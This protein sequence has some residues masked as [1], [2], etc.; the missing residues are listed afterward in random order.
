MSLFSF[1][2]QTIPES[3]KDKDWHAEHAK[4]FVDY[5]TSNTYYRGQRQQMLKYYR[6]YLAD[7]SEKEQK[8]IRTIT[9]PYGHDLGMEFI[10]YPLVEMKVEQLVG[11]FMQRPLKRKVYVKNKKGKNAK[12]EKKSSM[13]AES[14]M[15][16]MAKD[17]EKS[18][19]FEPKTQNPD[20]ELPQEI[21]EQ[22]EME[23]KVIAEEVG[24]DLLDYFL[25]VRREGEK[26]KD[27]IRD[28]FICDRGHFTL[29]EENGHP[30]IRGV[31]PLNCEHDLDPY[32]N[33][34]D[35][36]MYF[37]ESYM[38]TED[39]IYN[40][41]TLTRE[42]KEQ[43]NSLFSSI[44]GDSTTDDQYDT[45]TIST[46][47][48][49]DGWIDNSSDIARLRC[50]KLIWKSRRKIKFRVSIN[51][52]T[53]KEILKRLPD[54]YKKR[55]NDKIK[56]IEVEDPRFVLMAGPELVLEY[57]RMDERYSHMDS[58][59]TCKLPVVSLVR[60]N[61]VGSSK[62]RSVAAKL[63]QLQMFASEI[64][65]EF[66]LAVKRSGG[67]VLVYDTAQ[68]PK[69]FNKGSH[70]SALNQVMHHV[71]KDQML[72]INS[73]DKAAQR[74]ASFNQ[75]TSLDLSNKGQLQDLLGALAFIEDLADKFTGLSPERQGQVGQYQT[76][77]GVDS[78]VRGS[79][80]RTEVFFTP[81]DE[82]VVS[83]LE[84]V[85]M[86][87]K[88][89]YQKGEVIDYV[90]GDFKSKFL[91]L[92]DE[93]FDA[94]LGLYIADSR[95]E[96]ERARKI[97]EAAQLALANPTGPEMV[98]GLIEIFEGETASEKKAVFANILKSLEKVK[99]QNREA[100]AEQ[101]RL[102]QEALAKKEEDDRNLTREGHQKDI[103][104]ALIY[105]NNKADDTREKNA[106]AER[107]KAAELASQRVQDNK[108]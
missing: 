98:M 10:V 81:F 101:N 77:T 34:Q 68:T 63:Y 52:K 36:H 99:E 49:Y 54:N 35:D 82:F 92:F 73:K 76:A 57:G 87:A 85:L 107:I 74:A 72:F 24:Q 51:Q 45:N 19:G 28:Y 1:P 66:R 41:H 22:E 94:D 70:D 103:D 56:Q 65:Y 4:S 60:Q 102:A 83:T 46:S 26:F 12:L 48:N 59:K 14:F 67:R 55:K 58:P 61:K 97:D 86:K 105:A 23:V 80:A 31:H 39:Q 78:A 33:I 32:K 100:E 29:D 15:R 93:F 40:N 53:G 71:K 9:C 47:I 79:T 16:Q 17:M 21:Q 62:I 96:A 27:V 44:R 25:D 95:K 11:E 3:K 7:L 2:D 13:I 8:L 64:L 104:V 106:S 6:A 89:T 43:L 50:V 69:Q 37:Y 38:M 42:E 20:V 88:K 108:E 75:F 90:L 18:L 5:T 30:T 84:K 91:V